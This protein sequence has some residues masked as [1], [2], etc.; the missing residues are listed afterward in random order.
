MAAVFNFGDTS[1]P[2]YRLC[3]PGACRARVLL[4]T[5]W[6]RFGGVLPEETPALRTRKGREGHVLALSV[7]AFSGLIL[8]LE[9]LD[10]DSAPDTPQE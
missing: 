2:H 1:A 5:E 7:P 8:G 6:R 3:L 4:H 10:D 9:G